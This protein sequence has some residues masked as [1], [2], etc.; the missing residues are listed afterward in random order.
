MDITKYDKNYNETT[1]ISKVDHI[2][3]MLL[4]AIMDNDLS[5]VKHYLSEEVYNN[6]NNLVETYKEKNYIRLFDEMNVKST[7]ITDYSYDGEKINIYVTL[8]SRYMDYYVDDNGDYVKGINDHRIETKHK[9]IFTK[10]LN[11]K[12]LTEKRCPN[13][14]NTLNLNS[15]G[16]CPYCK[17]IINMK[18]YDYIITKLDVF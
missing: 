6:F 5:S 2:F 12:E 8:I 3:I 15:T 9:I 18:D 1:F 11:T 17:Q 16:V 10:Y 14:G 13:C 4:S 7:E